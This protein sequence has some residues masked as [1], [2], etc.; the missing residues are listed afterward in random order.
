MKT[1][2]AKVAE[3]C[4]HAQSFAELT[5][6]DPY[7]FYDAIRNQA[8]L[9]WDDS[10]G[11][12][13]VTSY[14]L[15]RYVEINEN[16]FR[17]PYF[18]QTPDLLE[19]KGGETITVAQGEEHARMHRFMLRLFGPQVIESYREHHIRPIISEILRRFM[20]DGQ[21]E[22]CRQFTDLLPPRVILSLLDMPW[23]NDS[24]V[25]R[26]IELHDVMMAWASGQ[27]GTGIVDQ[28]KAASNE[29]NAMI[30]P[31]LR[32]RRHNPGNDL[33][34]RVW[35]EWPKELGDPNEEK[36]LAVCR[37]MFMA[38][39]ETTIHA[40]ANTFHIL[41]TNAEVLRVVN[42]ERGAALAN[43]IEEGLR[44]FGAVQYRYRIA[45]EDCMLGGIPVEKDQVLVLINSAANRDPAQFGNPNQVD[46]ARL[47]PRDHLA[48]NAGPRVCVG[49][50]LARAEIADAVS[51]V[52]DQT[53]NLRLDH[54]LQ[55]AA[56][57]G[58]FNRSFRP[59]HV[60]FD[61]V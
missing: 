36:V 19:I 33:I 6:A 37:E 45:N 15:C 18:H 35:M 4:P 61:P 20:K 34:S 11:G 17:H 39:S 44:L 13:L 28:A 29:L 8:P 30:L 1:A 52:L 58:H 10:A 41:L 56:F 49:A 50:G 9:V 26:V 47:R 23:Q 60:L 2:P 55:G 53:C 59:L 5:D 25:H 3:V 57:P 42:V 48:F 46:I 24:V 14:E 12:W 16:K 32:E 51:A 31:H 54:S 40:L 21:A 27:G 7:I 22:L 43:L 38:G